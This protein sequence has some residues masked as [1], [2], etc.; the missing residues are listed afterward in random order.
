LITDWPEINHEVK[1]LTKL[2]TTEEV[3]PTETNRKSEIKTFNRDCSLAGT[4][5]CTVDAEIA[6][7]NLVSPATH[8]SAIKNLKSKISLRQWPNWIKAPAS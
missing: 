7:S 5:R 6:S 8:Q 2:K 3:I 4:K 1:T